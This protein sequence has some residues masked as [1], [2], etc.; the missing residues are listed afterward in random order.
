MGPK[1]NNNNNQQPFIQLH[2]KDHDSPLSVKS[3]ISIGDENKVKKKKHQAEKSKSIKI[4]NMHEHNLQRKGSC[5]SD[6]EI[7]VKQAETLPSNKEQFN[8]LEIKKKNIACVRCRKK[9]VNCE[10]I[11]DHS[12]SPT[13]RCTNC[14]KA[15]VKCEYVQP[16]KKLNVSLKYL[17]TLQNEISQLKK[18][19]TKLKN[20]IK[21][22]KNR[23]NVYHNDSN[24]DDEEDDDE[25][26]V[27]NHFK[28]PERTFINYSVNQMNPKLPFLNFEKNEDLNK[29]LETSGNGENNF[30]QNVGGGLVGSKTGQKYFVGSSSMTLFCMEIH[31]LIEKTKVLIE[32]Q[33]KT[34][35]NN[36]F[37]KEKNTLMELSEQVDS[38]VIP[39]KSSD[40][41]QFSWSNNNVDKILEEEGNAYKIILSSNDS[42]K[43]DSKSFNFSLP[44]YS[45]AKLLIDTFITYNDGCFYF[46]NEGLEKANLK[47][48]YNG[49]VVHE[50]QILQTIWFCKIM[51]IFAIGEMYLGAIN[52]K[53][54]NAPSDQ[55]LPG[56]AFF[57][58]SSAIFGY[59]YSGN[60][61]DNFTKP[62]SVEALLLY[63]FYLQ[64]ADC[65]VSSYLYFSMTLK[66]CLIL[67]W[68]SDAE[69]GKISTF[70]LEHH[71]RLFWTIYIYETMLSSKAGHPLAFRDSS[72]SC[73]LPS[74][75]DMSNPPEGCENYI[76]PEAEYLLACINTTVINAKIL[77]KL[78]NRKIK[79]DISPTV[80]S[81]I[82]ELLEFKHNLPDFLQVDFD[83][84]PF[85]IT[86]LKCNIYTEFF[87]GVNLAVRRLVYHFSHMFLKK[88]LETGLQK[89]EFI[90]LDDYSE[91]T[92][93]LLN[94]TLTSSINTIQSLWS[95][96]EQGQLAIF[97]YMDR[98]YIFT[99]ASTLVLMN[100]TFGLH[101]QVNEH[102]EKALTLLTTMKAQGNNP[103]NLRKKQLLRLMKDLNL[104]DQ[105]SSLISIF[106]TDTVN[107]RSQ[108]VESINSDDSISSKKI[109]R[110][111]SSISISKPSNTNLLRQT[112]LKK[113]ESMLIDYSNSANVTPMPLH[114][115]FQTP[116][117]N[118]S[119]S[120][121]KSFNQT[122]VFANNEDNFNTS[123][124]ENVIKENT[125]KLLVTSKEFDDL[126]K[127]FEVLD[128]NLDDDQ[129]W[130]DVQEQSAW[131][132]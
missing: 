107:I 5:Q 126:N 57:T 80:T 96:F 26:S 28:R 121:H 106:D 54:S 109:V 32:K 22:T 83:I 101:E 44:S 62:G 27:F 104:R 24:V 91:N 25:D 88:W 59:L 1:S 77:N 3:T 79:N 42:N 118:L 130:K 15:G 102:L 119:E 17:Q 98:E 112:S 30:S 41:T 97:G 63:A 60:K 73:Q 20:D 67:G 31:S 111:N 52:N 129:L 8:V 50:D 120:L 115:L 65:T 92:I 9:H 108:A 29:E 105:M 84:S 85:S 14:T 6:K 66:T 53:K 70:E 13:A 36:Q 116:E 125:N 87:N 123:E 78:Y 48:I 117:N 76:F 93:F 10:K 81:L 68:H 122:N 103:A 56:T 46:F 4:V 128:N 75:F 72:I 2:F 45:Y 55:N 132:I 21:K 11:S 39:N 100:A 40:D 51:L 94:S 43:N 47:K 37:S 89:P 49:E 69:L 35:T 16:N 95:M 7:L 114:F 64:V 124:I 12:E 61:I 23:T 113:N 110:D 99:A 38:V 74:D 34:K 33:H 131:L 19:N 58:K 71:R 90:S 86:R 82:R 127:I 18:E